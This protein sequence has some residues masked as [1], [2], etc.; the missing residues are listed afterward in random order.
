[1]LLSYNSEIIRIWILKNL[2]VKVNVNGCIFA[3]I[4]RY[5][6]LK[7]FLCEFRSF[8]LILSYVVLN[9]VMINMINIVKSKLEVNVVIGDEDS[10]NGQDWGNIADKDKDIFKQKLM[11]YEV[12]VYVSVRGLDSVVGVS[13]FIDETK[14]DYIT[15][16]AAE[17]AACRDDDDNV[18]MFVLMLLPHCHGQSWHCFLRPKALAPLE[19][20]APTHQCLPQFSC[21][22]SRPAATTSPIMPDP[23]KVTVEWGWRGEV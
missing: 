3:I 4:F 8:F 15:M 22:C 11:N 1:M 16:L 14:T 18:I 6:I 2:E 12:G 9:W 20:A 13:L 17:T 21:S 7:N 23:G 5:V 19:T 10:V